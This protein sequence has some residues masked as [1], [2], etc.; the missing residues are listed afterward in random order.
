[1][2]KHFF[3]AVP[4]A[5]LIAVWP[6]NGH[7]QGAAPAVE[8]FVGGSKLWEHVPG[9]LYYNS[10]VKVA[11]TGNLNRFLGLEMDLTKFQDI[12]ASNY[13]RLMF[14]PHFAYNGNSHVSPFAHAFVG[15]TRDRDCP[16]TSECFVRSEEVGRNA[17]TTTLA[18]GVDVKVFRF[19]WVRLI[20]ADYVHAFFRNAAENNLQLSFG[21]TFRFGRQGKT[22]KH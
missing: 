17:F 21:F 18:G 20:E 7:G 2:R 15:L 12:P 4:C 11:V 1:M 16:P 6:S 14:G 3:I 5:A 8:V 13:F 22:G 9:G 19:L 10:G